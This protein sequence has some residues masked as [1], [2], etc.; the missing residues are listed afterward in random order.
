M[1]YDDNSGLEYYIEFDIID[2]CMNYLDYTFGKYFIEKAFQ[3]IKKNISEKLYIIKYN[4][5]LENINDIVNIR[6]DEILL[7]YSGMSIP[8]FVFW[9]KDDIIK[10]FESNKQLQLEVKN[11]ISI[12][13]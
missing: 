10:E 7:N 6:N 12:N 11:I 4:I 9:K 5:I 13:I 8:N 3:I 2:K 1:S